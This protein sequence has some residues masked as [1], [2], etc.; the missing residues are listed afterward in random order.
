MVPSVAV[1]WTVM[2]LGWLV[3]G[4]TVIVAVS[5]GGRVVLVMVAGLS[6]PFV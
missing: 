4:V 5:P 3:G 6:S 2:V 1:T